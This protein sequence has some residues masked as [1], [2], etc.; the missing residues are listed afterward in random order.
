LIVRGPSRAARAGDVFLASVVVCADGG[1]LL[2]FV[3]Q[4]AHARGTDRDGLQNRVDKEAV[5]TD[6]ENRDEDK[7]AKRSSQL[8]LA[9][10][11]EHSKESPLTRVR[12][13]TV[14]G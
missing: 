8:E 4:D 3:D 7:K 12:K 10:G 1:H 2:R 9:T 13:G 6:S 11:T 5:A 14:Q